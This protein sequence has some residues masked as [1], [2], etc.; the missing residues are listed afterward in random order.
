M[1]QKSNYFFPE[2]F[3]TGE[4]PKDWAKATLIADGLCGW[5]NCMMGEKPPKMFGHGMA[6]I[7][8][9]LGTA[10]P[11]KLMELAKEFTSESTN[12]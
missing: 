3:I 6:L 12:N 1:S 8:K 9:E 7:A 11:D 4:L 2:I 5:A 10:D